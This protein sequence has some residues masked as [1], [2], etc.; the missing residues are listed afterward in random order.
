MKSIAD[1]TQKRRKMLRSTL[2]SKNTMAEPL[3]NHHPT[4]SAN[5]P[6]SPSPL[7]ASI[8]SS[9]KHTTSPTSP[10]LDLGIKYINPSVT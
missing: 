1:C 7:K 9:L 5:L 8:S 4:N 10:S 2:L 6:N 3:P